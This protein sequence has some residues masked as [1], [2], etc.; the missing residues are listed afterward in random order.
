MQRFSPEKVE[1]G[2]KILAAPNFFLSH[3]GKFFEITKSNLAHSLKTAFLAF[4]NW[5]LGNGII[6][7]IT[8]CQLIKHSI[9]FF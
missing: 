2:K 4:S 5:N 7:I 3:L 8:K 6:D 9:P 1:F